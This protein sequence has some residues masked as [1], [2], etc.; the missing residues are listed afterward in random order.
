[1]R[2]ISLAEYRTLPSLDIE[3]LISR[4]LPKPGRVII[5]GPPKAGKSFLAL[6]IALAVAQGQS[7][8]LGRPIK[9][10]KVLYLQFD[11]PD[12]LWKE[13]LDDLAVAGIDLTGDFHLIHPD[14]AMHRVDIREAETRRKIESLLL[15][16]KPDLVVVD[17]LRK[18]HDAQENDS[19]EMKQVFDIINV[20]FAGY[21]L[22]MLHHTPKL[23]PEF[24]RPRPSNALRGSSFIGGEV[25]AIWLLFN[26]LL[27]IES[28]I[29]EEFETRAVRDPRSGLWTFPEIEEMGDIPTE[30]I[31]LCE[32]YPDRS[33]FQLSA[34]VKQRFGLSK[35]AYYRQMKSLKCRHFVDKGEA[36]EVHVDKHS[37]ALVQVDPISTESLPM[38]SPQTLD[39]E[40]HHA[41]AD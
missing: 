27:T 4:M 9:K 11:T 33:H 32:E 3:Y 20:M 29:D 30:L 7:H 23:N 13:R 24:G 38:A 39:T 14:D 19:T 25:E 22:L 6:Q 26:G 8:F 35:S 37:E 40:S 2:S 10:G 15:E 18:I 16:V 12:A 5:T 36:S 34:I 17:V 41:Q 21:A 31:K 1:M 28:R